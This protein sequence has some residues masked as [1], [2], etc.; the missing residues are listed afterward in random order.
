MRITIAAIGSVGDV[1]PYLGLGAH[2]AAN[3][4]DVAIATHLSYQSLVIDLGLRY[5]YVPTEPQGL[6]TPERAQRMRRGGIQAARVVADAFAPWLWD[7]AVA[8][9][10][11]CGK[12]DVALLSAMAWTGQHSAEGFGIPS[13]GVHLQPMEPTRAFPPPAIG[14]TNLGGPLNLALGQMVQN[15]MV[16]PYL[17]V[18]NQLRAH[19]G[20]PATTVRKAVRAES[21]WPILY[22]FS[23]H[24][25]PRPDDWREKLAITGYWWPP[26]ARGWRPDPELVDFL[27]AGPRPVYF[28]FGSTSPKDPEQLTHLISRVTKDLRLRAVVQS[29]WAGLSSDEDHIITV[30]SVPHQWLFPRMRAVV[31]H[32]GA[33]TT[34]AAANAGVPSVPVPMALDQ[35]FW[36]SRIHRAGAATEPI[37]ARI[38]NVRTLK[39]ALTQA[40]T[41]P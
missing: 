35:P 14:A 4:H 22:G 25:L 10:A 24:L 9:D 16:V 17:D 1:H 36:A 33:G 11:A 27:Q 13:M 38:L 23:E 39:T 12:A 29:G 20:L 26:A 3:G 28:G 31:H 32:A 34:A 2:L 7:I 15:R 21:C 40:L 19:H 5:E 18:V 8:V 37:P 30:P 6:L 41:D